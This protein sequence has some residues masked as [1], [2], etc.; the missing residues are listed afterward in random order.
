MS[1]RSRGPLCRDARRNGQA[2]SPAHD[3][4]DDSRFLNYWVAVS[5]FGGIAVWGVILRLADA[6][7]DGDVAVPGRLITAPLWFEPVPH[8]DAGPGFPAIELHAEP[9]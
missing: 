9:R 6:G 2:Q 5:I 8:D 3:A 4:G 7:D 1:R